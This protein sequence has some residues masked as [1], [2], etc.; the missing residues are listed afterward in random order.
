MYNLNDKVALVTG[1]ARKSGIGRAIA[2]RMAEEG[3]SVVVVSKYRPPELFSEE[4]KTQGWQG[5]D[6][7]VSEIEAK[8]GRA[9][10]IRAD[11]KLSHEVNQMV[12]FALCRFG[13]ID[14]LINNA[15]ATHELIPLVDLD[16]ESWQRIIAINLTGAFLCSK[17]VAQ[18]IIQ[19]EE[20][21]KIINI[22]S[23]AGKQG[24]AGMGAYCAS[25]FGLIGLTQV[26]ALELAPYRINVNAI[27]PGQIITDL[28]RQDYP[29]L[30]WEEIKEK[31]NEEHVSHIPLGRLGTLED[32]ANVVAFL[33]S[34]G[35]DYM[36]GQAINITGG[37]RM[38]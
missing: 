31:V 27:C 19:R 29:G 20:G 36:T 26:L 1:A 15:G 25:K 17:A 3:A 38:D 6:S 11:V 7:L 33:A 2:L 13:K 32:V 28:A 18:T 16:E 9:L 4:E 10:A 21:G 8:G 35:S 23:R 22:C 5:L 12:D 37:R 14:I 34:S 24:I 30:A